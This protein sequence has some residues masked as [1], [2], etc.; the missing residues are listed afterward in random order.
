MCDT[1]VDLPNIL[2]EVKLEEIESSHTTSDVIYI[3]HYSS[4]PYILSRSWWRLHKDT[5]CGG[6]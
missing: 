5:Y 1:L 4:F 2:R 6:G 3:I